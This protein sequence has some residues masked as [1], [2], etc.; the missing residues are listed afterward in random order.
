MTETVKYKPLIYPAKILLAWGEAIGGNREIRD[1]LGKN[2]YPELY[3]F[4]FALNLKDDARDWLMKNK[5]P[6]LLALIQGVERNKKALNWLKKND[7]EVLWKMALAGDGDEES[8]K[9]LLNN[10]RDFAHLAIKIKKVKDAIQDDNDD[11]H[12]ISRE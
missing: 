5:Y 1:W 7:F 6:H 11:P 3:T 2:G 10:H 12:K 8:L 9:W 4:V